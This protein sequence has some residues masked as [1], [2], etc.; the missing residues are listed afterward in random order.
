MIRPRA[1]V[2]RRC[3]G[4]VISALAAI[5]LLCVLALNA[6]GWSRMRAEDAIDWVA[7]DCDVI[8]RGVVTDAKPIAGLKQPNAA[9][10]PCEV[11][12]VRVVETIKGPPTA[13][14][15][16]SGVRRREEQWTGE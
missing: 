14:V 1:K 7:S 8:V 12:T 13:S 6:R 15:Q 16:F 11:I 10:P 9:F 4:C 5:A 2:R 3:G